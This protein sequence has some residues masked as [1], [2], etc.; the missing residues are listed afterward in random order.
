MADLFPIPSPG[1]PLAFGDSGDPLVVLLHDWYGRLPWLEN[2]AEALARVGFRVVV[3]DLYKGWATSS[4]VEAGRLSA[5]RVDEESFSIIDAIIASEPHE[6]VATV[7][8]SMG[9]WVALAHAQSGAVD[10]AVTYYPSLRGEL[11]GIIPAPVQFHFA[12]SDDL[13]PAPLIALLKDSGTPVDER[14]YLGTE[15][16]FANASMP[17]Q[18]VEREAALAFARTASFLEKHLAV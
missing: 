15:H 3:P 11:A 9:G 13:D 6:H 14:T 4:P 17:H 2:Y 18:F 16:G 5:D 12:E 8:W 10:A 1:V 7:G